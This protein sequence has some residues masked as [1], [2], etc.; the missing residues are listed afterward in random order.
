[1]RN[2]V[3][4]TALYFVLFFFLPGGFTPYNG[5]VSD[6]FYSQ[7]CLPRPSDKVFDQIL[8]SFDNFLMVAI[9]SGQSKCKDCESRR[10]QL[11]ESQHD[12]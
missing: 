8:T 9:A 3:Q 2:M 11:W 5:S 6:N 12:V 4:S 1:M 7:A 10:C